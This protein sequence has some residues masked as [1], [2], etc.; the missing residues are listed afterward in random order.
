MSNRPSPEGKNMPATIRDAAPADIAT[1]HDFILALAD[2]EKLSHEV[3]ARPGLYLE[4]LFVIP[5]ALSAL[6]SAHPV[7]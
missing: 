4:D 7:C 1:I 6:A 3:K 2:Y 5:E